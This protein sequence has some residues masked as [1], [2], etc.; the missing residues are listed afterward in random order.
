[1]IEHLFRG[2][3][4]S[5]RPYYRI[6]SPGGDWQVMLVIGLFFG[7]MASAFLS[8]SFRLSVEPALWT[9]HFGHTPMI[10]VCIAFL[11][12]TIMG[13]GARWAGGC[14]SGHGI[15]G[16]MQWAVSSWVATIC[17]FIGGISAAWFLFEVIGGGV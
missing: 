5:E 7:A 13:F 16:T 3:A 11:G 8:G 4:A 10:R 12:G 1:M 2:S 15:S 6:I 9:A 17:F 14:T